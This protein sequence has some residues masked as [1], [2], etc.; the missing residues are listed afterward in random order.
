MH[1]LE[2]ERTWLRNV[3]AKKLSDK[4]VP[5][6]LEVNLSK[7]VL[8]GGLTSRLHRI[9]LK[10]ATDADYLPKTLVVKT[11]P[12]SLDR[13]FLSM[14]QGVSREAIFYQRFDL[15]RKEGEAPM[16]F[17]PKI[18]YSEG[19]GSKG[20]FVII[21][22]DLKNATRA[23]LL[24]GNQCWGAVDIPKDLQKPHE[25]IF[26]KVFTSVAELHFEHWRDEKLLD[27]GWLKNT[28][29]LN[30]CRRATWE[31]CSISTRNNWEK[32]RHEATKEG[33]LN[34]N[35][36]IIETM[37][38]AVHNT[39]WNTYHVAF[40]IKDKKTPFTLVH[41]DF[42]AGNCMW[43]E[44][45]NPPV[46]LFDWSEVSIGDPYTELAQYMVSNATIDVRRKHEK[47]LV[48]KYH[49][50]LVDLGVDP[51]VH[52]FEDAWDRY[53]VGGIEKWIQMLALLAALHFR[54][55]QAFGKTHLAWFHD[56]VSS[57][58][59]DHVKNCKRDII[60]VTRYFPSL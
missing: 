24:L 13:H 5:E 20:E 11:L 57:F 36:L 7:D 41:G 44:K 3:I 38:N 58:L 32:I 22:E 21:M 9:E 55:P 34:W 46:Y 56:Q 19:S 23:G 59:E 27:L 31:L 51:T 37:D 30:G 14:L 33:G 6:L 40:D 12:P 2:I 43:D 35:P 8:Q 18:Y 52:T 45:R 29:W 4:T 42:H 10:W 50:K 53:M 17:I 54:L 1:T 60:L 16:E 48:R 15:E 47:E 49:Q 28:H 26:E 25:Y 39:T